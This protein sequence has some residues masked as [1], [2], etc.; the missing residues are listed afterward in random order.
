MG[1]NGI[2]VW[3]LRIASPVEDLLFFL[4]QYLPYITGI[5]REVWVK[6]ASI[7]GTD[8]MFGADSIDGWNQCT[9]HGT[10]KLSVN[11]VSSRSVS[12]RRDQPTTANDC[13]TSERLVTQQ[14][15]PSGL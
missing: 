11:S 1:E 2:G 5:G 4:P 6:A 13:G 9:R 12:T 14:D 15:G 7:C 3:V 10:G 8:S